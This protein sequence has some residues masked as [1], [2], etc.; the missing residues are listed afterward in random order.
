MA[1]VGKGRDA[2]EQIVDQIVPVLDYGGGGGVADG[3]VE[4]GGPAED[5]GGQ[6]VVCFCVAAEDAFFEHPPDVGDSFWGEDTGEEAFYV[7]G[8]TDGLGELGLGEGDG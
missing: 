4:L 3:V 1:R 7:L 6:D 8:V 2:R 5:F